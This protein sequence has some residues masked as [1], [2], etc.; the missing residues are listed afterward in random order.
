MSRIP[1]PTAYA[2][3]AKLSKKE[4]AWRNMLV[5]FHPH[6]ISVWE[7]TF[8]R[9]RE[10]VQQ[11]VQAHFTGTGIT[12]DIPLKTVARIHGLNEWTPVYD[13]LKQ[14]QQAEGT[15]CREAGAMAF[16]LL[17]R[18]YS[19]D[20]QMIT[21]LHQFLDEYPDELP[22]WEAAWGNTPRQ[23]AG[24]IADEIARRHLL[25]SA[26]IE[27]VRQKLS[28]A[29]TWE[30]LTLCLSAKVLPQANDN[31]AFAYF[32]DLV[33]T[34]IDSLPQRHDQ[35]GTQPRERDWA[36][37]LMRPNPG[38]FYRELLEST[39]GAPLTL[40]PDEPV[41]CRLCWRY[42]LV[43]PDNPSSQAPLCTIC[44]P[45]PQRTAPGSEKSRKLSRA[46]GGWREKTKN[47]IRRRGI[48]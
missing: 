28:A 38:A 46:G 34:L 30:H 31:Y 33:R 17:P 5:Q 18:R 23:A 24:L 3:N 47:S 22:L 45:L 40:P 25:A 13:F 20:E 7:E 27:T 44:P 12:P 43:H 19:L 8:R 2:S 32:I 29:L 6:D 48:R 41:R 36:T 15:S 42:T 26:D 39:S 14:V 9:T 16:A 37:L 10:D 4:Q 21:Y 35:Y 1:S 11:Y